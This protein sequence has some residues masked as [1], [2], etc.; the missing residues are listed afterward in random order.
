MGGELRPGCLLECVWRNENGETVGAGSSSSGVIVSRNG[1][2]RLTVASHT[3]ET[4]NIVYH[5]NR[6]VDNLLF[7]GS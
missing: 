4:K 2:K 1:Q 6:Q 3:W 5:A 7:A